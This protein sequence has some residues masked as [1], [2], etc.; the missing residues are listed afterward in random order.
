MTAP[1]FTL[2]RRSMDGPELQL[3][4]TAEDG[5]IAEEITMDVRELP[6]HPE[7]LARLGPKTRERLLHDAAECQRGNF[8]TDPEFDSPPVL[9]PAVEPYRSNQQ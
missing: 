3:F 1:G 4:V 7:L 2:W 5:S 9:P 8:T 6:A